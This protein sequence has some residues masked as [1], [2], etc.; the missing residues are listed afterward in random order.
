M[1]LHQLEPGAGARL[2]LNGAAR[3]REVP[4]D[5][6][7]QCCVGLA[8]HRLRLH[9]RDPDAIFCGDETFSL[10]AWLDLDFSVRV[11]TGRLRLPQAI[12]CNER[13]DRNFQ[14]LRRNRTDSGPKTRDVGERGIVVRNHLPRR[15]CCI[16][17]RCLSIFNESRRLAK[18][19]RPPGRR[20]NAELCMHAADYKCVFP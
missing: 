7:Q 4:R 5:E 15:E 20:V 17:G 13:S 2:E 10:R 19:Q 11:F 6:G 1:H 16:A 18:R 8:I 14:I 12:R 9:R 3:D